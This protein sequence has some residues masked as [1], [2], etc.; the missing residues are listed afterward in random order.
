L[1]AH[2][3]IVDGA[4]VGPVS[5]TCMY[6]GTW[7]RIDQEFSN[8]WHS[9]NFSG[10]SCLTGVQEC[11]SPVDFLAS[12]PY[13]GDCGVNV[14]LRAA[15]DG[16]LPSG[17]LMTDG[18][19]A[20]NVIPTTQP[21]SA[22][23]YTFVGSPT[24]V[25]IA[26]SLLAV[27]GNNAIVDWVVAEL[28]SATAPY[29]IVYSK[30]VLLQRDGDVIDADG[31]PH[32]NFPAATGSYRVALRHRNHLGVMTGSAIAMSVDPGTASIDLRA[33]ISMYGTNA[34]VLKGSVYCMWAGDTNGDDM[35]KYTGNNNDR[36]PILVAI[37][38]TTP[39]NT[40]NN[41]YDRRDVNLDGV[42]KYTGANNDRDPILVNI[43]GTVPT[44]TRV[45]QLP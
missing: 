5:E 44:N 13:S 40:L 41:V 15:L 38:G 21:Y 25:S 2:T 30:P 7:F 10:P 28:R 34:R 11:W 29:T 39:T 8:G 3:L 37:G 18:L 33:N 4:E 45:Q 35:L 20:A 6:D 14:Y 36:D 12:N 16:A 31:A 26:P 43:G 19:R 24:N 32:V 22:L 9:I 1:D 23:G 27:T 17:T 42:I